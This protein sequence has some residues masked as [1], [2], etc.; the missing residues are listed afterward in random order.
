MKIKGRVVGKVGDHVR[1]EV[2]G[3]PKITGDL[4]FFDIKNTHKLRKGDELSLVV[5]SFAASPY[6]LK[7]VK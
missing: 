4:K 3:I 6:F 7:R 2:I 1:L 5:S